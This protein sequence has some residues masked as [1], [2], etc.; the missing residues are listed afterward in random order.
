VVT[1][2]LATARTIVR[3]ARWLVITLLFVSVSAADGSVR[4]V[5]PGVIA[6]PCG[7]NVCAVAGD[8]HRF[9]VLARTHADEH[10]LAWSPDGKR[11]AFTRGSELWLMNADGSHQRRL[12]RAPPPATYAGAAMAWTP[13]GRRI[14]FVTDDPAG[15]ASGI[16]IEVV[17]VNGSGLHLLVRAEGNES[18]PAWS[19]DGTKL[20]YESDRGAE[21]QIYVADA[22]GN[23]SKRIT[24][25]GQPRGVPDYPT[26]SPDGRSI[27]FVASKTSYPQ[28]VT[29]GSV[30]VMR[31]DGS[32]VRRLTR[33]AIGSPP[34]W[35]PEGKLIAFACLQ[36]KPAY[37]ERSRI[38]VVRG[39]G[40]GFATLPGPATSPDQG[41]PTPSW[42]PEGGWVAYGACARVCR[43]YVTSFSAGR[44]RA[45]GKPISYSDVASPLWRP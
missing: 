42:S 24:P 45:V 19:P 2:R 9:R 6:F 13:D 21:G 44:P 29:V 27:A 12:T 31:P 3:M 41:S 28:N 10:V 11:L 8:G 5:L 17:T 15:P 36:G 35:S 40:S 16:G 34:R 18:Q 38:C 14:A 30:Y 22:N 39:D 7:Y 33:R 32:H 26:W 23:H 4:A 43:I 1:E 20:A 25:L 37:E